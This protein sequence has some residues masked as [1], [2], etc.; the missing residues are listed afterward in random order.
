MTTLLFRLCVKKVIIQ[1]FKVITR[2]YMLH[3]HIINTYMF[4]NRRH[5]ILNNFTKRDGLQSPASV[6]IRFHYDLSNT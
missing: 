2:F 5:L 4:H 1:R 6:F 3:I